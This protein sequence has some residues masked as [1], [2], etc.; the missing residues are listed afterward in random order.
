VTPAALDAE[1]SGYFLVP[2][3]ATHAGGWRKVAATEAGRVWGAGPT[4]GPPPDDPGPPA[5]PPPDCAGMCSYDIS[6]LAVGVTLADHPVGYMPPK[7]PSA[8][9]LQSMGSGPA[10]E[11]Q[12]LERRPEMGVELADI[13]RGRPDRAGYECFALS[14]RRLAAGLHGLDGTT[15][16]FAPEEDDA[17]ILK[18]EKTSPIVYERFLKDGTVETYSE[19]DGSAVF[20]R[21]VFL[22][23]ITDPQG[24]SLTLDYRAVG[25]QV[26]LVS[27]TDATGRKTTFSYGSRVSPLSITKITDPFGRS[28][29]L[30]YD[31]EGRLSSITDVLGLTSKFTYDSSSLIDALTTPYGTT[32]FTYGASN[33]DGGTNNRRFVNVI[34]PLGYGEREETFEPA[35]FIPFSEPANEVPT[36]PPRVY[37][38]YFNQ[39]LTC[40]D[41]FHWNKHQYAAA[42]CA[43]NGGCNY[44]DARLTHFTHDAN[45]ISIEWYTVESRKEPLEKPG[46][47]YLSGAAAQR[48]ARRRPIPDLRPAELDRPRIGQ[49]PDPA[50]PVRL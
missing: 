23:K 42:G 43:P 7:G 34:D 28:A 11:L 16:Q 22:T 37:A 20:P 30:T 25:G 33:Q 17:S 10:G 32:R 4:A 35:S 8:K 39:Y 41:S 38:P 14:S 48:R 31:S 15:H 13:R 5:D 27:L 50:D 26:R 36:L 49:R 45:N 46:L 29:E 3:T 2:A 47:V 1:T 18:L 21:N 19:S 9:V 44:A 12:L 24:N 6:E 40:R